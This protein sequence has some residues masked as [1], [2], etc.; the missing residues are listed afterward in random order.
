MPGAPGAVRGAG[1]PR[2]FRRRLQNEPEAKTGERLKRPSPVFDRAPSV[3]LR[4]DD[5]RHETCDPSVDFATRYGHMKDM[6]YAN[7]SELKARLSA[8]L[9]H[10]RQGNTVVVSDRRTPV[11]RLVPVDQRVDGIT[12]ER[13]RRPARD[14]RHVKAVRLR[15]RV[16]VAKLLRESREQR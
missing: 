5:P 9:A 12:I 1:K 7:V 4:R 8:Y 11:A 13:A 16:D 2:A 3:S 14:L 15:R 6:K 10:V